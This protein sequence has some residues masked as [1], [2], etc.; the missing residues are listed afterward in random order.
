MGEEA[1]HQKN[2][3]G[4]PIFKLPV[5]QVSPSLKTLCKLF[6]NFRFKWSLSFLRL[7]L[8]TIIII[9]NVENLMIIKGQKNHVKN[10]IRIQAL[11]QTVIPGKVIV[12]TFAS[13]TSYDI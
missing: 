7:L 8:I 1:I 3:D 11:A 13:Q 2:R 4:N 9:I 10:F 12:R 5:M 6:S